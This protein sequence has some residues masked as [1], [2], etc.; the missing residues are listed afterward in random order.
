MTKFSLTLAVVAATTLALGPSALF[1]SAHAKDAKADTPSRVVISE[2]VPAADMVPTESVQIIEARVETKEAGLVAVEGPDGRI[3]YN[4]FVPIETLPD[5]TL[6]LRVID[7]VD[8]RY[9]GE[10]YT[11]KVVEELK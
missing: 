6:D 2:P 7:T 9:E 3:Y 5:P 8:I 10:V 1:S 4:R 11:N